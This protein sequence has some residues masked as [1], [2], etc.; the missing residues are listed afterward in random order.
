MLCEI[1]QFFLIINFY[2]L[3]VNKILPRFHCTRAECLPISSLSS[4]LKSLKARLVNAIVNEEVSYSFYAKDHCSN[5]WD[6]LITRILSQSPDLAKAIAAEKLIQVFHTHGQKL[7]KSEIAEDVVDQLEDNQEDGLREAYKKTF[8]LVDSDKSGT[9]DKAELEAWLKMCGAELDLTTI[10][11]TLTQEGNLDR[12]KFAK[13]MSTYATSNRRDYD[14]GG[15]I[16]S[17]H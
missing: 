12:D 11:E 13:L 3:A 16:K 7:E 9:L 10:I 14:I 5:L 1:S 4:R 2:K 6:F 8:D 17:S 15:T